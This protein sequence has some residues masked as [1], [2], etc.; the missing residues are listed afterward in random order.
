M[1]SLPILL[2]ACFVSACAAS[3]DT[4]PLHK[5]AATLDVEPPVI[6][7]VGTGA[8]LDVDTLAR[9]L[10]G[11]D[12]IVLGEVHD[13]PGHHQ[14]QAQLVAALKPAGLAFEMVPRASEE[15]IAVFLEQ[16]GTRDQ[17]GPAIGWDR[18]GWPDWSMYSAIFTAAPDAGITG[19]ALP[20]KQVRRA[21][22]DGA[23][24]AAGPD[25]RAALRKPLPADHQAALEQV[26]VDS[27]CGHLP[28]SAAPGMVEGQRLRDASFAAAILRAR[29]AGGSGPV[30]LITGTGHA[31]RDRGV[32]LYLSRLAPD[33]KV[34]TIGMTESQTPPEASELSAQPFDA[35]VVTAPVNRPNPCAAFQ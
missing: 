17:I 23:L 5:V 8:E 21:V 29:R 15:G 14:V 6:W 1:R 4:A 32:P 19:G 34:A 10:S 25:L 11:A 7:D 3:S 16:G 20:R 27:H 30:I 12:V 18:M 26:M 13:N 24:A 28:A 35:L 22:R 31:H 33:L 9:R 2:L